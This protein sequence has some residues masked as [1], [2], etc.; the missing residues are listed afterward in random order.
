VLR[1]PIK[2]GTIVCTHVCLLYVEQAASAETVR[3]ESW[4]RGLCCEGNVSIAVNHLKRAEHHAVQPLQKTTTKCAADAIER[5]HDEMASCIGDKVVELPSGAATPSKKARTLPNYFR[6]SKDLVNT[7]IAEWLTDVGLPYQVVSTAAFKR[8][9]QVV[10]G[11][12]K[13]AVMTRDK[14]NDAVDG[15]FDRFCYI[16]SALL[17]FQHHKLHDM[18][19]LALIHDA[20]TC[21]SH[22]R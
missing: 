9:L 10:S 1:K 4:R 3:P 15:R 6:P 18:P 11:N 2:I 22:F 17:A 12:D 7:V 8:M 16:V 5:S 21:N 19:F 13:Q 14:Y 20:W